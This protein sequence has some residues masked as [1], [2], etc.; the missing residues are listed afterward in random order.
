MLQPNTRVRI[1]CLS[2]FDAFLR[3]LNKSRISDVYGSPGAGRD[4]NMSPFWK[5]LISDFKSD[6]VILIKLNQSL[7]G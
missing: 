1:H 4:L 2:P 7:L 6:Y 5:G 3:C